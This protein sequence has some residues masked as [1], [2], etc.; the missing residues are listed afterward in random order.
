MVIILLLSVPG[1]FTPIISRDISQRRDSIINQH[2]GV[3]FK[4][5]RKENNNKFTQLKKK[6]RPNRPSRG[7]SGASFQITT[8]KRRQS[9]WTSAVNFQPRTR[10]IG[11]E[12]LWAPI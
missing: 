1:T 5:L 6:T 12:R 9:I 3:S 10:A 11:R 8:S 4:T 2:G 7:L